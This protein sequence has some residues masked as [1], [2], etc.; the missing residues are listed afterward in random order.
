M[1]PNDEVPPRPENGFGEDPHG[2]PRRAVDGLQHIEDFLDPNGFIL[3]CTDPGPVLAALLRER[4]DRSLGARRTRLGGPSVA[5]LA[6]LCP[7]SGDPGFSGRSAGPVRG[8]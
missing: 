8:S 1:A 3:P 2:Y 4:L 6:Y 7:K 5:A